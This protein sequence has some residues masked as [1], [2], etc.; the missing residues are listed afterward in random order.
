MGL[1]F[2]VL[3]DDS[4]GAN[5]SAG[6]LA[7]NVGREIPVMD[8]LTGCLDGPLVM[9][10]RSREDSARS[11]LVTDW[12]RSLWDAGYRDFD[13]RI[14]T[15][16]RGPGPEELKLLCRALPETPWVGVV[17]AYPQAGRVTQGG[18]QFVD[19]VSV[20]RVAHVE[21]DC[22][23]EYL[24]GGVDRAWSWAIEDR[25]K[26]DVVEQIADSPTPVVFDVTTEGDLVW[27]AAVLRA[28][29]RQIHRPI[30]TV[31]SGA[32][33][34]YYPDQKRLN[35]LVVVGSPTDI[36]VRQVLYLVQQAETVQAPMV[37]EISLDRVP[38]IVVLHSGLDALHST[39]RLSI[40][41]HLARSVLERLREL[42][43][44]GWKPDRIILTGGEMAQSFLDEAGATGLRIGAL[45]APL[46][47][48]GVIM[49]GDY[50]DAEILTKGGMVG[51]DSLLFEL[52]V[53]PSYRWG[54]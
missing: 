46:V 32:L 3:A 38:P 11:G 6:A 28:L 12:T 42:G 20:S 13:K 21:T 36:N 45:A 49:G 33:L 24:F 23:A 43:G 26:P 52:C 40:S 31:S 10:T 39:S 22:L 41:G 34:Q 30:V 4:T 2:A 27:T 1:K 17:S 15:T 29:R 35:T 44:M 50:A 37:N 18:R 19:G 47:G 7:R 54:R 8:R 14:D 53:I 9:N 5:A 48:H 51:G 16:L 25:D